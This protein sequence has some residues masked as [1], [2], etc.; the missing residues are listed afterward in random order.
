MGSRT[1]MVVKKLDGHKL[2]PKS[3]AKS[4]FDL[5]FVHRLGISKYWPFPTD[6]HGKSYE[7]GFI[8]KFVP[9]VF[10]RGKSYE[11]G[12]T[13]KATIINFVQSH[14]QSRFS[15]DFS[16]TISEF[17]NIGHSQRISPWEV[18]RARFREKTRWSYTLHKVT[19]KVLFRSVFHAQSR[20][21]KILAIPNVLIIPWKS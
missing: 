3:H 18:I 8:K 17:Q 11:H 13:K 7:H 1:S 6:A 20:N 4:S 19:R 14:A 21:F 10:A 5:Y 15:I 12:F 2:Y 16:C 9:N